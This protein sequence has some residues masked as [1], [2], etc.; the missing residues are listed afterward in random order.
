MRAVVDASFCGA[1]V[2][3]DETSAKAESV[4]A[5]ALAG[6]IQLLA[7]Q[8]WS[9][10]MANL[11]LTAAKRGR[12]TPR[13]KEEAVAMISAVPFELRDAPDAL[14]HHRIQQ[15]AEAHGLSAYDAAYLELADRYRCPLHTSD[16]PLGAAARRIGLPEGDVG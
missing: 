8:L 16:G 11:L 4:L 9:Y 5:E 13:A 10:E 12:L 2:L 6:R 14:A 15:L 3:P 1:W 7:P